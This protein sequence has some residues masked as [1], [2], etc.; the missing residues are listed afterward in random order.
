MSCHTTIYHNKGETRLLMGF[1]KLEGEISICRKEGLA[2]TKMIQTYIQ[3]KTTAQ[4]NSVP[5]RTF[6]RERINHSDTYLHSSSLIHKRIILQHGKSGDW[7][8]LSRD[9]LLG[10]SVATS[11][12][13]H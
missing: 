9:V 12:I 1:T 3:A 5:Y 10:S 6:A 8:P 4:T 11:S 13:R 2:R 7:R